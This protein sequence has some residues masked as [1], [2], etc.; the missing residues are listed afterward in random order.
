[1]PGGRSSHKNTGKPARQL[2]FS[3]AFLQAK[4]GPPP[5]ATQLSATHQDTADPAQE[6]TMGRILQEISEVGRR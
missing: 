4:G 6:P 3:E 2:L 5:K 1:M